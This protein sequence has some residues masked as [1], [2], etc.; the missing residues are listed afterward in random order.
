MNAENEI[1]RRDKRISDDKKLIEELE[2]KIVALKQLLDC[3]AA[4]IAVL[5]KETDGVR[6]ISKKKVSEALGKYHLSA[7]CDDG[8]NYI[9]KLIEEKQI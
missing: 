2:E 9:L 5:V 4:N 1:K 3:A 6:K 8:E 7:E